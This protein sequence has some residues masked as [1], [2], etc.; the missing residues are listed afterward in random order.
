MCVCAAHV[1]RCLSGIRPEDYVWRV[2]HSSDVQCALGTSAPMTSFS[3]FCGPLLKSVYR[4]SHSTQQ[5]TLK[6][7]QLPPPAA[8]SWTV[9]LFDIVSAFPCTGFDWLPT[10]FQLVVLAEFPHTMASVAVRPPPH[11]V[12]TT[13]AVQPQLTLA[14]N[15]AQPVCFSTQAFTAMRVPGYLSTG[16][17]HQV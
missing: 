9:M 12:A 11:N 14:P 16:C 1:Y 7:F 13:S 2:R 17:W 5:K 4:K 10:I 15:T 6:L 8:T 3:P